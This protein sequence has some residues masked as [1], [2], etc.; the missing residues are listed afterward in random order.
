M[1]KKYTIAVTGVWSE[2]LQN[3]PIWVQRTWDGPKKTFAAQA[4]G[5]F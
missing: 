4:K 1:D 2:F 5:A 3:F